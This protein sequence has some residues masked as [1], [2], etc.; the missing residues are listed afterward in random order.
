MRRVPS[1]GAYRRLSA[2]PL[3]PASPAVALHC[4]TPF[5]CDVLVLGSG[6]AGLFYA[7][8]V[9]ELGRVA[10]VTKKRAADS[11]TN[12]A[13]GG[14]A[15]VLD[16]RRLVRAARAGHARRRARPVPRGRGALR[17]RARPRDD[18]RAAQARRRVRRLGEPPSPAGGFDLGREGGHTRRRILHHRDATGREIERALLARA[19]AHPNIALFEDH[20]GVDLLTTTQARL[21]GPE[22]R[23]RRL[24]ARRRDGAVVPLPRA[25]DA[26]RHRRR[27]QGLPLHEQPR[28]RV[29]R[30]H[31][32]GL[33]RRRHAR[34]HGVRPVPPDLPVPPA[35]EV[36]PDHARRCAARAAILRT[37]ARRRR[38]WRA[39]TRWPTSRRAT[40][41]RARS[42]PSSS[43]RATTACCSTSRTAT[44]AFLR[45]R[46]PNIY[47]RCLEFGID[48]TR[49]PIPVVPAA[50]YCCGGVATDLARRDRR[51]EP[52]R[53][54]RGRLHRAARRE[55]AGVELAARGA[56]V[57]RRRG[58]G[59]ASRGCASI[60]PDEPR[61][62]RAW[63]RG[64]RHR[65][66]RGGRD[67]PELGRD[68]PLH[69]ELRRH[70]AQRPAARARAAPHRAAAGARSPSTTGTSASRPTWSSCATS[71]TVAQLVIECAQQRHE[72][73]GLHYTS[74][75]RSATT[76]ASSPTRWRLR[77]PRR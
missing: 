33:S 5:R 10:I 39:T 15:A 74:T 63:E 21:A 75:T 56:G 34:E 69:V 55:P 66:R 6:I 40:S 50:H 45:E 62:R 41:S 22:P 57:R 76:P 14:I 18:R 24:R 8:R 65:E 43:A 11:A 61:A 67:H 19:R 48:I 42:T 27:G 36:V 20:C 53:R 46:F 26:A 47:E 54:R 1:L 77:A 51:R 31:G 4:R 12:W 17:G 52:V 30:R 44:P 28:H 49:E 71:R 7:L 2:G 25:R 35:G 32:D 73:R 58:A 29:R 68:P 70:R 16:A 3:S 9:A 37:Q 23:A 64:R 13:Q 59:D 38:S 60:A 72:S